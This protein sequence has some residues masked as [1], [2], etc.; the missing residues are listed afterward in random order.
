MKTF[1][2][3]TL[4][5]DK[6]SMSCT[7]SF[8]RYQTNCVIKF[9]FRQLVTSLT[10]R[11][12]FAHP[13]KQWLTGKVSSFLQNSSAKYISNKKRLGD[14]RAFQ[15][16]SAIRQQKKNKKTKKKTPKTQQKPLYITLTLASTYLR[17]L[18]RTVF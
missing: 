6:V 16:A 8:S 18:L 15:F 11:S 9:L 3:Y 10:L 2:V 1:L 5:F 14:F 17:I 13:L 12:I 7:F 4:S